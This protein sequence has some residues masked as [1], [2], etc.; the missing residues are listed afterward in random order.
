MRLSLDELLSLAARASLDSGAAFMIIG[1]CAR[2]V[3]AVP[4]ATRDV[5]LAVAADAA[6]YETLVRALSRAGFAQSTMVN[7]TAD[8]IPDVLL[9]NDG[10]GGRIDLLFA[11]TDFEHTALSRRLPL[12]LVDQSTAYVATL[13][14]LIVYKL[15]AGRPRDFA[16][17]HEMLLA[18]T[19]SGSSIDWPHIERWAREWEVSDRLERARAELE[20]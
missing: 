12:K 20:H 19:D 9:V 7:E 1:G 14:D 3:Y 18:Q 16:D 2:N 5:D 15:V 8:A 4:R 6:Q 10:S 17:V 11:K 13:E